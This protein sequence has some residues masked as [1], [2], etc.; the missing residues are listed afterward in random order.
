M[1]LPR[2]TPEAQEASR[3]GGTP[4]YCGL[5]TRIM[6][7]AGGPLRARYGDQAPSGAWAALCA[8][9]QGRGPGL[10]EAPTRR[11]HRFRHGCGPRRRRLHSKDGTVLILLRAKESRHR[12]NKLPQQQNA[13]KRQIVANAA[14]RP[15]PQHPPEPAN[16]G[17][18]R[19]TSRDGQD[20]EGDEGRLQGGRVG[21]EGQVQ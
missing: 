9:A 17:V 3:S 18:R 5:G 6:V 13:A 10:L 19:E 8:V 1:Q 2:P 15:P 12:K 20:Q 21:Q 11:A 16:P 4:T 7:G 14:R